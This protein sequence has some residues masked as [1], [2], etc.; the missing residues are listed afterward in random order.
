MKLGGANVP[1]AGKSGA[2]EKIG[3]ELFPDE[4][5]DVFGGDEVL[6]GHGESVGEIGQRAHEISA[7][8][9]GSAYAEEHWGLPELFGADDGDLG[10]VVGADEEGIVVEDLRAG[11][12]VVGV[13]QADEG[14][15]EKG[16][17]LAAG[18]FELLSWLPGVLMTLV[19]SVWTWS[20]W[21]WVV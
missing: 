17:E 1:P 6:F 12:L 15:A 11:W 10:E 2:D 13:V 20:S 16:C 5:L 21:W 14:V 4:G 18:C 19:R 7:A 9:S 8:A 3:D